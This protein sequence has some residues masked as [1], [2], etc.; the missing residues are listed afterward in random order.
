MPYMLSSNISY[1]FTNSELVTAF[2]N[3]PNIS[4][5]RNDFSIW[6]ERTTVTGATVP[7]HMR[8]AIDDKP[9]QYVSIAVEEDN[10]DVIDYNNKYNTKLKG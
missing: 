4:N 8:Y 6:G 2:T 5:I 1:S 10:E 3:A 7:I 9:I